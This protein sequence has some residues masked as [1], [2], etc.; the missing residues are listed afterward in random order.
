MKENNK[1]SEKCDGHKYEIL[2]VIA[3]YMFGVIDFG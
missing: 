1:F 3:I 2:Q